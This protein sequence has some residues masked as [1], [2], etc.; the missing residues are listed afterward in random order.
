MVHGVGTVVV[1]FADDV[2]A[3][4]V[5]RYRRFQSQLEPTLDVASPRAAAP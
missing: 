5:L 1:V 4:I 2:S 3:S